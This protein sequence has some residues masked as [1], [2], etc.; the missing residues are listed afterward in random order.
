MQKTLDSD[1]VGEPQ[2]T[3]EEAI[4]MGDKHSALSPSVAPKYRGTSADQTDMMTLGKKQVLRRNFRFVTML[5]FGSTVI[6][7]WEVLLPVFTFV[8]ADGGYGTLF[9]GFI[10]VSIGMLLVYASLAEMVSMCPTAGGQYHWVSEFAPPKYQ[11]PLSYA[12]GWLCA[13]GWQVF[14][15]SVAFMIGLIALNNPD[16]AFER[17]HATLLTIAIMSFA[18]LFNTVLAVRLPLVEGI[19]L[20]LHIAG[21][22]GVFIPLWVLAPR[23]HSGILVTFTN[24]GG[25]PTTG[26]AAMIGLTTPLTALIGYDCSVHMSEE[27]VDASYSMP[28][29]IMWTVGPNAVLGFLMAV[30]LCFTAGDPATL[31]ETP[32]GQ[33]FIQVFY[34]GTRSLGGANTMCAIVVLCLTSCCISEV[35][36]ASRQLWSFARD[37]GVPFSAWICHVTPRWNIPLRSVVVS[38]VITSLLAC[39]N[40]G[41]TTA[42][43]AINSL[44]GV[45]VLGSYF[46]TIACLIWRRLYGAPLPPRRWSLGKFGLPINIIALLFL[47]PL[48]FFSFWPLAR[49]VTAQSMNWNS[50]MFGGMI[51]VSLAYYHLWGKQVYTGPV[52]LV[53]RDW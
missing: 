44:G 3:M 27:I 2:L 11:K 22:F 39:I 36:T 1:V 17:W 26:I 35:A 53:K 30:T 33:P 50:A 49:P 13:T 10:I 43:N 51:I 7:S 16:Y 41:S 38:F 28:R 5:G 34:N 18:V 25:W 24:N 42:L 48:W 31:L 4:M 52:V 8:L 6:C 14:L 29:A 23:A 20:I 15:A 9:W 37:K 40:L 19:I 45:S 46:I 21:F 32:T 12:T 47:V